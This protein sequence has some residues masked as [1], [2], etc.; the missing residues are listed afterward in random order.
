[1]LPP[2]FNLNNLDDEIR[3]LVIN[4]NR[5]PG[6]Y[7]DTTC[8][9]HVWKECSVWPA[10]DGWIH[11]NI[12]KG[13]YENLIPNLNQFFFS[14]PN[15]EL[16]HHEYTHDKDLPIH[17]MIGANLP[18][19]H[20]EGK[21]LYSMFTTELQEDYIR[22]CEEWKRTKINPGWKRLNYLVIDYIKLNVT[23]DLNSLPFIEEGEAPRPF[24][25]CRA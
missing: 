24:M 9:G 3:D 19:H 16:T 1:M 20:F 23:K 4:I 8:E 22:Y 7:T 17:Y 21:D 5:I 13:K 10:K 25:M 11:L 15:F 6:I 12:P 2:K 18:Q 14:H